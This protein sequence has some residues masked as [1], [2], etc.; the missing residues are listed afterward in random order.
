M[1]LAM[2]YIICFVYVHILTA[3]YTINC[4]VVC[5]LPVMLLSSHMLYSVG[6]LNFLGSS[7]VL[8]FVIYALNVVRVMHFHSF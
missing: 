2:P 4:I 6:E 3:Y 5:I 1:R 7:C 8:R